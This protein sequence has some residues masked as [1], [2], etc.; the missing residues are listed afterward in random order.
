MKQ[1][2]RSE[3][4]PLRALAILLGVVLVCCWAIS[5]VYS[6]YARNAAQIGEKRL[7]LAHS[8]GLAAQRARV[9]AWSAGVSQRLGDGLLLEGSDPSLT[10]AALQSRLS[11]IA[12]AQGAAVTSFRSLE[13]AIKDGFF[14]IGV[15]LDVR[16]TLAAVGRLLRHIEGSAP[17]L[18]VERAAFR[19]DGPLSQ[20]RDQEPILTLQV[21]VHGFLRPV[22]PATGH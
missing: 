19:S 4:G 1:L 16:G 7:A 8:T 5:S 15:E 18:V 10:A 6:A 13:P 11:E 17:L 2:L 3:R 12:T 20:P 9:E 21:K 14:N 22:E